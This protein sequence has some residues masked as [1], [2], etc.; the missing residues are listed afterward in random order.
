M[1]ENFPKVIR[2]EIR[3]H[4][5]EKVISQMTNHKHNTSLVLYGARYFLEF[6]KEVF[7]RHEELKRLCE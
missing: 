5:E 7:E 2:P 1:G 6:N 4:L 3:Q